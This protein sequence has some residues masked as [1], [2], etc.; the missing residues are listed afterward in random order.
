LA[1]KA[2]L[3][4]SGV[5]LNHKIEGGKEKKAMVLICFNSGKIFHWESCKELTRY[6]SNFASTTTSGSKICMV[7]FFLCCLSWLSMKLSVQWNCHTIFSNHLSPTLSAPLK[8][9]QLTN[10]FSHVCFSFVA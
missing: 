7:K 5:W 8:A 6:T 3:R 9:I 4:W 10:W 1:L 2:S